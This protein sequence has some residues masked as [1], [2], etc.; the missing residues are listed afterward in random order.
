M[1]PTLYWGRRTDGVF[2]VRRL[3]RGRE[4]ALPCPLRTS[5]HT[6]RYR[7]GEVSRQ[8]YQLAFALI[9]DAIDAPDCV[10]ELAIQFMDDFVLDWAADWALTSTEIE[11]WIDLRVEYVPCNPAL[12]LAEGL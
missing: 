7:W 11:Q 6:A 2:T 4:T 3:K 1:S 8:A 9:A 5:Q 12:S 10:S